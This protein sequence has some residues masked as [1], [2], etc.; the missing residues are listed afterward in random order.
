MLTFS[1]RNK[2]PL[3][4]CLAVVLAVVALYSTVISSKPA[5]KTYADEAITLQTANGEPT[6]TAE[7]QLT[8]DASLKK[9]G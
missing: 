2:T 9:K 8:D 7:Q 5:L 6:E 4:L 3:L 1:K